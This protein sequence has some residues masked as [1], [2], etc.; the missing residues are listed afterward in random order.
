M[1]TPLFRG[2]HAL[3]NGV[4]LTGG[5][6]SIGTAQ[7]HPVG[8]PVYKDGELVAAFLL[9]PEVDPTDPMDAILRASEEN[10][11]DS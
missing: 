10:A 2:A 5:T 4:D 11:A 8:I 3:I 7:A 9:D 1:T 6:V